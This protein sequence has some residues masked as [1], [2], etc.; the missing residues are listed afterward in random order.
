MLPVALI[1]R[2]AARAELEDWWAGEGHLLTLV[3]PG[4]VGKTSLARAFAADH[5]AELVDLSAC[6]ELKA[7]EEELARSLGAGPGPGAGAAPPVVL[8][9]LEQLLEDGAA[10]VAPLLRQGLRILATSRTPLELPGERC[11]PLEPLGLDGGAASEAA[12]L[13]ARRVSDRTGRD[14]R[15]D[16]PELVAEIA[17]RL[18][19]LP[20]A[21]ELAASRLPTLGA[22][23]LLARLDGSL[24]LLRS[25]R[26]SEPR[27]ATLEDTIRWSWEL[28]EPE[29]QGALARL[30]VFEGGAP[31]AAVEAV[32]GGRAPLDLVD[33]LH[34]HALV[35]A[36][37]QPDGSRRLLLL[38]SVRVFASQRLDERGERA[39]AEA[40]H[41][42]WY[43]AP[44]AL[45]WGWGEAAPEV[46]N[47]QAILRRRLPRASTEV[48]SREVVLRVLWVLLETLSVH[49]LGREAQG[50]VDD[51][52]ADPGALG[53]E[54]RVRAHTIRGF[55]HFYWSSLARATS[56]YEAAAVLSREAGDRRLHASCLGNLGVALLRQGRLEAAR[57]VALEC[58]AVVQADPEPQPYRLFETRYHLLMIRQALGELEAARLEAEALLHEFRGQP[59]QESLALHALGFVAFTTGDLAR[60]QRWFERCLA[61]D[62]PHPLFPNRARGNLAMVH[63]AR[64]QVE[65]ARRL[66]AQTA[67]ALQTLG[68]TEDEGE[69]RAAWALLEAEA[70]QPDTA[71][72]ELARAEAC[73]RQR[74]E[75]WGPVLIELCEAL[76]EGSDTREL[77]ARIA[78]DPRLRHAWELR[79]ALSRA[80]ARQPVL[81]VGPGGR[82]F[83]FEDAVVDLSR[84][85]A[86]RRILAAFVAARRER[87][88]EALDRDAVF[89]AGWP[90]QSISPDSAAHRVRVA[91][92]SLRKAGLEAV[93]VRLGEGWLLRPDVALEE[94]SI[95]PPAPTV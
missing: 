46:A 63:H 23:G 58:L 92:S 9:N 83:R 15:A 1:G 54:W 41:E 47:L 6:R 62:A 8:D 16:H 79:F 82:W 34:R 90:G 4:G 50:V 45:S 64:G 93:L 78:A 87:P 2:D 30:S 68:V 91:V 69:F 60:A 13:L 77:E 21:L 67:A 57:D 36:R 28:L 56:D 42:A 38:E 22:A 89:E 74:S 33:E 7:G 51:I 88:G 65:T 85:G 49:P 12:E 27:H 20:L 40:A 5:G 80:H 52:I 43:T 31:P 55:H 44:E 72:A 95:E 10:L 76:L 53:T 84:R 75:A 39:A 3:G 81:E 29:A 71:R 86:N 35:V 18:D 24:A 61:V 48:A 66:Y 94:G 14:P 25:R 59:H 32:I 37:P 11:L 19:G 73:I 26:P 70:G 17:R